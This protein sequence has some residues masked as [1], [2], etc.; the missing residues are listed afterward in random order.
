[1]SLTV[2]LAEAE[3]GLFDFDATLPLM[4]VQFLVLVAVLNATFYKPLGQAIDEMDAQQKLVEIQKV[5]EQYEQELAQTRKQAQTLV[6]N[7]R[8]EAQKIAADQFA[9]AQDEAVRTRDVAAA[10]IEQQK[11]VAF[12]ALEQQVDALSRRMLEKLL[13]SELANR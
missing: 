12:A 9:A 13:G 2:L 4:A 11:Q 6:A 1:M 3:G 5:T 7:A 8:A 10:E